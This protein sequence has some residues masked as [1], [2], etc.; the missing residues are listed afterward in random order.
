MQQ[1]HAISFVV[2]YFVFLNTPRNSR[3]GS[4]ALIPAA[5]TRTVCQ[6][7]RVRIRREA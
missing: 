7:K 5:C 3:R 1:V 2:F 4:L 6:T